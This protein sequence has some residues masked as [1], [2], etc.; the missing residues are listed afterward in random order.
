MKRKLLA[1]SVIVMCVSILAHGTLAFFTA[2]KTAHNVITS[3]NIDIALLEWADE[4][5]EVEFPEEG[6]QGILPGMTQTKIVEVKN[7]GDNPAYIRVKVD[8]SITL[9]DETT[10][11]DAD[12]LILDFNEADWTLGEDGYYC[13]NLPLLEKE[14]T[15][16]LFTTVTFAATMG[17]EYQN[18]TA[19]IDV[20][21]QAVQVA[22]NGDGVFEARGW[23]EPQE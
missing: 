3:G 6:I 23:P 7:T 12:L 13:Y 10:E 14:T 22:N 4:D 11:G 8:K 18:S 16:P 2:E 20:I 15:A 17:N 1:L 21:A 19:K 5:K 9:A